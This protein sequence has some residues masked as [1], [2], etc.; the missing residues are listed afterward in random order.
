ML[1]F[2]VKTLYSSALSSY[3][4]SEFLSVWQD[5]FKLF[6]S[7]ALW[8]TDIQIFLFNF[9]QSF[10]FADLRVI[11]GY[12]CLLFIFILLNLSLC[13]SLFFLVSGC[14]WQVLSNPAQADLLCRRCGLQ[15]QNARPHGKAHQ[16]CQRLAPTKCVRLYKNVVRK[17]APT[18]GL[19]LLKRQVHFASSTNEW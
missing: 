13:L 4:I 18:P 19:V 1:S 17:S 3:L 16:C 6:F 9:L 10:F 2:L 15:R 11:C 7:R 8:V 14:S 12:S 5:H